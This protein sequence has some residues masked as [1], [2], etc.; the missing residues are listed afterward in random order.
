MKKTNTLLAS[1]LLILIGSTDAFS[2]SGLNQR[3]GTVDDYKRLYFLNQQYIQSW[4]KSDTATYN[5]LLWADDFVHQNSSDGRLIPKKAISPVFG[6][7][8]F[9]KLEYFYAENVTIQF[10]TNDAAMV[11]ARTPLRLKGQPK[12]YLSQYNDVYV[13]RDGNWICVSA[14]ISQISEPGGAPPLMDKLPKST[15]LI[16]YVQGSESDRYA[17]KELNS[18]HAEAFG[19]SKPELLLSIL[20]EDFTL[21]A[22][23]GR[24]Y[25]KSEVLAQIVAQHENTIE[26]YSIEN[27]SLRF[28]AKDVA[29]IHAAF[30]AKHKD[31]TTTGTQYN[32]I[33]VKRG[34]DW[35]CVGG[36]NTPIH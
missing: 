21:L 35:V 25:K 15:D 6:E 18:K 1:F 30:V 3:Y 7:L 12:E 31:G 27:Y 10:I 28:V 29:M 33:Y 13:R 5:H 22:S 2:Q 20:A 19:K 34:V 17:L 26:N 24:L 32:D 9:E 11:Y 23:N 36:N 8:R 4:I 14:N 16:T